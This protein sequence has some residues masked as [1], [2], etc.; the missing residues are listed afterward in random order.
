VTSRISTGSKT[1]IVAVAVA[2]GFAGFHAPVAQA[3]TEYG[4]TAGYGHSDNVFRV[5]DDEIA[6]DILTAGVELDWQEDR[7]RINADVR[8]DLDFNHY[9]NVDENFDVDNQVTGNA[10]GH[11]TLGIVPEHFTW[12]I[13][14]SFGQTQQDPL[15]PATPQTLESINY[16]TTGPDFTLLLGSTSL[17]RFSGRYSL[18]TYELSPFDSSRAGGGIAFV[19][20][21]SDRSTLSLNVDTDDVDYDD[22]ASI[23]FLRNSASFTYTLDA[24]RTNINAQ[25]GYT[26]MDIDDGSENTGPLLDI[27]VRRKISNSSSLNFRLGTQLS[28]SAEALR[29][30]LD[31]E[32]FG[33]STEGQFATASTFENQFASVAWEFVRPRTT[34][35]VSAGWDDEVYD[36]V[37]DFDRT[38]LVFEAGAERHLNSRLSARLRVSYDI[39][40]YEVDDSEIEEWRFIL[41]GSWNFGRDTGLELWGERLKRDS[42]T[43]VGGGHSVENRI[44]LTLFYRPAAR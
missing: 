23:D 4:F 35:D 34:F 38:R 12:L 10:S 5:S 39:E 20:N 14:D 41:G 21:T 2:C 15:V 13:E 3:Q 22:P 30:S 40:N 17:L 42:N 19:R 29:E 33:G 32:D 24:A 25:V 37:D 11:V 18:S 44:F 16:L 31:S 1:R 6:S 36:N 27:E 7:T 8:A 28:D 9:L 26:K 43:L